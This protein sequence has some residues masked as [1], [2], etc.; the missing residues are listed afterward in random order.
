MSVPTLDRSDVPTNETVF[1]RDPQFAMHLADMAQP[2]RSYARR[3]CNDR[4]LAD[5]LVQ[6]TFLRAWR[7]EAGFTPGSQFKAW[8]YAILKNAFRSHYRRSLRVVALPDDRL[9]T[10]LIQNE[11][12]SSMVE[13]HRVEEAISFLPTDQRQ[14]L[15]MVTTG[16]MT[17]SQAAKFARISIPNLKSR[18]YRARLKLLEI[19]N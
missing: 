8:L 16:G 1:T 17:Y 6:E 9:V 5:D 7:S 2:L 14:A 4:D 18:V 11:T 12:Q 15:E 19:V 13:L 10:S 3:L